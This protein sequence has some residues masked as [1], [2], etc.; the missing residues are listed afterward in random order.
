MS[1][2]GGRWTWA[3]VARGAHQNAKKIK[4]NIFQNPNV[5]VCGLSSKRSKSQGDYD[6]E[7]DDDVVD[8]QGDIGD[9]DDDEV[10]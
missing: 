6:V 2:S 4:C 1:Y 3:E 5:L 7:H 10:G 9:G 8:D